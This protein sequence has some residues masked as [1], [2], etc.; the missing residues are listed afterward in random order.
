MTDDAQRLAVKLITPA[1]TADLLPVA[2][3]SPKSKIE[4]GRNFTPI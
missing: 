3:I 2:S 4:I 1:A